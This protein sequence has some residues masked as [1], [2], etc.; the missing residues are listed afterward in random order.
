MF[1]IPTIE[2]STRR[3]FN[4]LVQFGRK[5]KEMPLLATNVSPKF[6]GFLNNIYV[7]NPSRNILTWIEFSNEENIPGN[8]AT[9]DL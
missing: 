3:H 6:E 1:I 9:F 2:E 4:F 5:A 7:K 8:N